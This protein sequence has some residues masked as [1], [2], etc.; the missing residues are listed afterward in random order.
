MPLR[1]RQEI[2]EVLRGLGPAPGGVEGEGLKPTRTREKT[3]Y[4]KTELLARGW[5]P[6]L[7]ASLL[8]APVQRRNPHYRKAAPML[9]WDI[10]VVVA[11]EGSD[12]FRAAIALRYKREE[13]SY[14][15]IHD[16]LEKKLEKCRS[17]PRALE[18]VNKTDE[19]C[20]QVL[21]KIE[22][23]SE[24]LKE[25]ESASAVLAMS[26]NFRAL[27][28]EI[29]G[30]Y[31]SKFNDI[32]GYG[33]V[34]E[35]GEADSSASIQDIVFKYVV[36]ETIP[37]HPK[38]E[39]AF[40]RLIRR[41]FIIHGGDTNTG[42][43]YHALEALKD[44]E[45]GVYLAPLRLLALQVFQYLTDDNCPCTLLT[46]EEEIIVP[47]AR[48]T[49]STVEKLNVNLEYDVAVID[50]AQMLSDAQ[51]GSAWTKAILGVRAREVHVCCSPNAVKIV[52]QLIEECGDSFEVAEYRRD[53]PL[54]V[55]GRPF[56]FPK[57]VEPGD[58]LIAFSKRMVLGIAS[59]LADKGMRVSVIYG[60]L[61]PETRKMQVEMFL[62]GKT[63]VVVAT[64]AIGMGLNL[65]IKRIVFM[66][67]EKYDG[68]Q[69]RALSV[70]EVKQ[71]SGR[72]GRKNIYDI[73]LVNSIV[74]KPEVGRKLHEPLRDLDE[75]Y[76]LPLD[77]YILTMPVGT[78]RERLV[79]SMTKVSKVY[80]FRSADIEQPLLLLRYIDEEKHSLGMDE[81]LALIF[82]PFDMNNNVLLRQ[83]MDHLR[84]FIRN[85]GAGPG[86]ARGL[87]TAAAPIALPAHRGAGDINDLETYYRQ[88]DLYYAFCKAMGVPFDNGEVSA[89]KQKTASRIHRLLLSEMKNIG[90]KCKKCNK[91][92]QWDFPYTVCEKCY[93]RGRWE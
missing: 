26:E 59:I 8:P 41:H 52:I 63:D 56:S 89:L 24:A 23:L 9:L 80:P 36:N 15:A 44:G 20:R 67:T 74:G 49:S 75:A 38:N 12:D 37:D 62:N 32:Y 4:N 17:L 55:D 40:T 11:A 73:G 39:Y 16:K 69:R 87:A 43:T 19:E 18:A 31:I 83:W 48:Y 79:E 65:P 13:A 77:R 61:P 86:S 33:V 14:S 46:G 7:I 88:L 71:I 54:V 92:L 6:K 53:V 3:N 64:D 1:E 27:L 10:G 21:A 81:Q 85:G 29:R 57:S 50:E 30:V 35:N 66:E 90:S 60:N 25:T 2:Q 5:T 58:A 72:A 93:T 78:L 51:R 68:T 76:Y 82:V 91:P 47:D 42:K 22:K 45:T 84:A 34:I 28:Y 70:S